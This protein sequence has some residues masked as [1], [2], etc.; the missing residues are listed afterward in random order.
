MRVLSIDPGYERLGI[1]LIE[2][3]NGKEH[4]IYSDCITTSKKDEFADRLCQIGIDIENL[5]R[6]HAPQVMVLE[7]LFFN[8]NQKTAMHIAEVRGMLLFIG[9]RNNMDIVHYTPLQVK[10]AV[11]G[12]G[13]GKKED[14]IKIVKKLIMIEKNIVYDDEYDA[15]AI[16]LTYFAYNHNP[17][18]MKPAK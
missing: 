9:K 11:S 10:T 3:E 1:A 4:L 12:Y 13:R 7:S 18:K 2:S 16:G 8:T 17:L 6:K 14:I 15:V 5:I